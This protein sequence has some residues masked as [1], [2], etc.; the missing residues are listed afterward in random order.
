MRKFI[1]SVSKIIRETLTVSTNK[2]IQLRDTGVYLQSDA[3]GSLK[4]AS[5]GIFKQVGGVSSL[6]GAGAI[7]VTNDVTLWETDGADAGTLADGVAGQRKHIIC[8]TYVGDGTLTPDNLG[9]G[10][11]ITFGAAGENAE[12]IFLEG[13]WYMIGGTATLA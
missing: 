1:G 12:L 8:D 11:T 10:T 3:D 6:T 5:D 7:D 4:I 9:N 2:K 13:A